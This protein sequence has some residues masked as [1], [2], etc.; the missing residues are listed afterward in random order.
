MHNLQWCMLS[1]WPSFTEYAHRTRASA[2]L[3]RYLECLD[4]VE[5]L[6]SRIS[7]LC[8]FAVIVLSAALVRSMLEVGRMEGTG[9]TS[10][11]MS[12]DESSSHFAGVAAANLSALCAANMPAALTPVAHMPTAHFPAGMS[13]ADMPTFDTPTAHTPAADLVVPQRGALCRRRLFWVST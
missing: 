11:A 1:G 10:A 3:H 7:L 2:L 13:A 9:Q 8:I 6:H 12:A 4:C 5:L